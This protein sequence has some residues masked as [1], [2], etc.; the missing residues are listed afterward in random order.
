MLGVMNRQR[1]PS[2]AR[3]DR[4]KT[5]YDLLTKHPQRSPPGL[6]TALLRASSLLVDGGSSSSCFSWR[7]GISE[8]KTLVFMGY[9]SS[10]GACEM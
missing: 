7:N 5:Y 2:E 10:R 6:R 4:K 3:G 1:V 9:L 8:S